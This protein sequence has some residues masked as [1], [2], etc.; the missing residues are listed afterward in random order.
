MLDL[1]IFIKN[2]NIDFLFIFLTDFTF[3]TIIGL[4][5][6]LLIIPGLIINDTFI[7]YHHNLSASLRVLCF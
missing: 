4:V 2:Q 6:C 5:F 3:A 1:C 7:Y